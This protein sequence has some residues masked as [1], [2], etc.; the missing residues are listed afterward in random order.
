M[1]RCA[2]K[3]YCQAVLDIFCD[4]FYTGI[5]SKPALNNR[6]YIAG[7]AVASLLQEGVV[8]DVDVY[9][10]DP[11]SLRATL[12]EMLPPDLDLEF[13]ETAPGVWRA[14]PLEEDGLERYRS[15][16]TR[17]FRNRLGPHAER[18]IQ[19]ITVFAAQ[20]ENLFQVYDFRHCMNYY[21]S[22]YR[23]EEESPGVRNLVLDPGALESLAS[24]QL[25]FSNSCYPLGA[26]FRVRKFLSR[27]WGIAPE[28]FLKLSLAIQ[29]LDLQSREVLLEQI[30]A[31]YGP[32]LPELETRL[33]DLPEDRV[34]AKEVQDLIGDVFH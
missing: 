1:T 2:V 21:E 25:H 29:Q 9:F 7:G 4:S 16:V 19:L 6:V 34:S 27:G 28:E 31:M 8:N 26:L 13:Q 23:P 10:R 33:K 14:V 22:F 32:G 12:K 15:A 5:G 20:P 11:A 18:P 30:Q 17:Q 3:E 24:R